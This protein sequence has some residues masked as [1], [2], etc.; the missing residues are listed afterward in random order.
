[1]K[2]KEDEHV[3]KVGAGVPPLQ[4]GA[5]GWAP[6]APLPSRGLARIFHLPFSQLAHTMAIHCRM[7]NQVSRWVRPVTAALPAMPWAGWFTSCWN[8]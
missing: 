3:E 8:L 4:R 7:H 6:G 5:G 1:M 2:A